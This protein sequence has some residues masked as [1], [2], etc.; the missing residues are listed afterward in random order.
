MSRLRTLLLLALT[1]LLAL[2]GV[3]TAAAAPTDPFQYKFTFD[4]A[5]AGGFE[6]GNYFVTNHQTGNVLV[7][8]RGRIV[9][10]GSDGNPVNF[11]GLGEPSFVPGGGNLLLVD[12][13]GGATQG[14]IYMLSSTGCCGSGGEQYFAFGPDGLPLTSN[15][16]P[17][18]TEGGGKL[19]IAGSVGPGSR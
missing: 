5:A 1:G 16:I 7:F 14:N 15:P 19:A 13:S 10:F 8:E 3:G 4:T 18:E 17:L 12:N 11:S 9:Q 6:G 2:A